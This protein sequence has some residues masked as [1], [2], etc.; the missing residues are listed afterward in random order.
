MANT[1][2]CGSDKTKTTKVGKNW[3][4]NFIARQPRLQTQF[5]PKYDY[6]RAKC[7]DPKL[8]GG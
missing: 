4:S 5:N 1:I 6:Q 8:I 3:T 2:L 7:E